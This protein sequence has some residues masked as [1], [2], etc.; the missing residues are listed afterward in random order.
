MLCVRE[1]PIYER[2]KDLNLSDLIIELFGNIDSRGS[3]AKPN[4]RTSTDY[5]GGSTGHGI[6]YTMPYDFDIGS[7]DPRTGEIQVSKY[8]PNGRPISER[9]Q[10]YIF[11]HE[12]GHRRGYD[13]IDTALFAESAAD[14]DLWLMVM[15]YRAAFAKQGRNCRDAEVY[16]GITERYGRSEI[17]P[18]LRAIDKIGDEIIAEG[19]R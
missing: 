5:R 2:M 16:R 19:K 12:D 18:L 4:F 17:A 14:P 9:A 1:G 7:Y 10:R 8:F 11:A 3:S 15:G 6:E 13:E